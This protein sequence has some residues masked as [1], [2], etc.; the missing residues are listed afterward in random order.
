MTDNE[1]QEQ[2]PW[3]NQIGKPNTKENQGGMS[4]SQERWEELLRLYEPPPESV[5]PENIVES[6]GVVAAVCNDL[7][8]LRKSGSVLAKCALG[9]ITDLLL[10]IER[11]EK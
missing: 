5:G 11:M 8:A 7:L 3:A 2:V 9:I 10:K 4:F 1:N 6:H